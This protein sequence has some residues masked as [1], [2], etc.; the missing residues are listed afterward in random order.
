MITTS[1][2]T[3]TAALSQNSAAMVRSAEIIAAAIRSAAVPMFAPKQEH[4]H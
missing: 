4:K 2:E 1:V 3:V